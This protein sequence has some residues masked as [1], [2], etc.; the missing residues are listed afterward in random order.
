M[1]QINTAAVFSD[2]GCA[3]ETALDHGVELLNLEER[4]K[5]L[6]TG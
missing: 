6:R 3:V 2:L 4:T 5:Q 1:P